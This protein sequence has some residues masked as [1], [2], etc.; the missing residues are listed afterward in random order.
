MFS[1]VPVIVST[2]AG[3]SLAWEI[4]IGTQTYYIERKNYPGYRP[5]GAQTFKTENGNQIQVVNC[6]IPVGTQKIKICTLYDESGI[7]II[8]DETWYEKCTTNQDLYSD[9]DEEF[10]DEYD[11]DEITKDSEDT[12]DFINR[13]IESESTWD[14]TQDDEWYTDAICA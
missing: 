1:F 3:D 11:D 12:D 7:P 9:E 14:Q 13:M 10:D 4:T 8:P 6:A 5:I 2:E